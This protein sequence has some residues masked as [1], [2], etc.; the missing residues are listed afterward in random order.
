MFVLDLA[1]AVVLSLS[2]A[3][4]A[5]PMMI[6]EETRWSTALVGEHRDLLSGVQLTAR[7]SNTCQVR[8]YFRDATPRTAQFCRGRVTGRYVEA[9]AVAVL[10]R[11]EAV[12]G[13]SACRTSRGVLGRLR[14]HT[15]DGRVREAEVAA[16]D[17]EF[18][19]VGC[20][21]GWGVQGVQVF[22]DGP[23]DG[24]VHRRLKGLRLLCAPAPGTQ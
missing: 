20:E 8:A 5:G 15:W 18:V 11:N 7:G 3:G 2:P 24:R 13:F 17:G 16:C 23:D 14:L 4:Q 19:E 6:G 10:E 21:P 1:L 12:R 9:S 22:F